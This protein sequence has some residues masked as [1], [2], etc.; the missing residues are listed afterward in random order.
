[1]TEVDGGIG[2][3]PTVM[4]AMNISMIPLLPP[5]CRAMRRLVKER[6]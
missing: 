2:N 3:F 1:M 5:A 4:D 6:E